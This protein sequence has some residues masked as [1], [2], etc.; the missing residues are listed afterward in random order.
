MIFRN[1]LI[2]SFAAGDITT[3]QVPIEIMQVTSTSFGNDW[4]SGF[5]N[6]ESYERNYHT[7][8]K[9]NQIKEDVDSLATISGVA[10]YEFSFKKAYDHIIVDIKDRNKVYKNRNREVSSRWRIS[11][12][13]GA[14]SAGRRVWRLQ[15][16]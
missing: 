6:G 13:A 10:R 14:G 15:D 9:Q 7:V 16:Y 12:L 8:H 2:L 11:Q 5:R 4:E 3:N 1:P